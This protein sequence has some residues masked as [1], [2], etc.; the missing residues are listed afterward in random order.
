MYGYVANTLLKIR[1]K[2]LAV[3]KTVPTLELHF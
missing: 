2:F 1:L 3:T